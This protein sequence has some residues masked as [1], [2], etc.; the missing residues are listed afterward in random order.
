MALLHSL[1]ALQRLPS[2]HLPRTSQ[3]LQRAL[4]APASLRLKAA[5]S[6]ALARSSFSTKSTG[7][8][9]DDAFTTDSKLTTTD[10]TS[11]TPTKPVRR[12]KTAAP[13]PALEEATADAKDESLTADKA[14]E[15]EPE[16]SAPSSTSSSAPSSSSSSSSTPPPPLSGEAAAAA[17]LAQLK[18]VTGSVLSDTGLAAD[19]TGGGNT[20]SANGT[21]GAGQEA[22]AKP[23]VEDLWMPCALT[24]KEIVAELDRHIIGQANAKRSVAIALRNRFRRHKLAPEMKKEVMPKNMLMIGPTGVG[25]TEIARRM[26]KLTDAP[27]LKVE[28]TKFTETGFHGRDVDMIIHDLVVVSMQHCRIRRRK[29]MKAQIDKAV[30]DTIIK[31]LLGN[32]S[33]GDPS[34]FINLLR[35]GALETLSIEFEAPIKEGDG[36]TPG[37]SGEFLLVTNLKKMMGGQRKVEK[38]RMPIRE[39]RPIIEEIETER[40]TSS[41][42]LQREA[43]KVA[44]SDGIVFIDEID[45]I[46]STGAHKNYADAS[47]EGV[48]RDLLPLIEGCTINTKFGNVET[49][50]ILFIGSGAFH[51]VKPSDMLPE[52]Q[53]RLPIRVQLDALTENDFYRILTETQNNFILQQKALLKTE[54]VTLEFTDDAIREVARAAAIANRNIENIGARRLHAVM[55]RIMDDISFDAS[56]MAGQKIIIDT[57]RVQRQVKDLLKNVDL[58]KYV[59]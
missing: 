5:P 25:K 19:K 20:V 23:P 39:A 54:E 34:S 14:T 1:K 51:S 27:F 43:I 37:N 58:S 22:E 48:Q 53:G 4:Y 11:D 30:E 16:A 44:E 31:A 38:K 57:A 59:L 17:F 29:R 28:A 33:Y 24:P 35:T 2:R 40:L 32:M 21:P 36:M 26:A 13:S 8:I 9:G 10:K 3:S 47:S 42:D 15:A 41:D 56:D 7:T 50:H 46:V 12:R 45:K 6:L 18:N 52:L 55:E 49:D